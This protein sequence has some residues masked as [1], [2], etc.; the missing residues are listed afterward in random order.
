M[1]LVD[2]LLTEM[3]A[4]L[5]FC[6]LDAASGF[7]A[8]MM[9]RRAQKISAFVC[10]LGHFEWLRMPFGLKNSPMIHQRMIDN[11]FWGFVQ[12]KE[13]WTNFS[14]K[15]RIAKATDAED[16]AGVT[17]ASTSPN[18]TPQ[19]KFEADRALS[20]AVATLVNSPLADMYSGGESDEPSLVPVLDRRSFV[21]DICCGSER[22]K[23]VWR[24]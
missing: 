8:V 7:W 12:P 18:E 24:R 4:Y 21:D 16:R 19:T 13:G 22:L 20:S 5:W 1:P 23:R 17:E 14:E 3:E 9:T 10:A 6:S 11:A 15:M 2:D